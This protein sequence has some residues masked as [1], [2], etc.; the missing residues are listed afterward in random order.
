[1]LKLYLT[2]KVVGGFVWLSLLAVGLTF[3][4]INHFKK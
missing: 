3:L 2:M 4:V 1:M